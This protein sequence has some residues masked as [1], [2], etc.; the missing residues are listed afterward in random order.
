MEIRRSARRRDA[1]TVGVTAL[2]RGLMWRTV[3]SARERAGCPLSLFDVAAL[4][5]ASQIG[6]C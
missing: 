5:P 6:Y 2:I 1:V 3:S 4:S